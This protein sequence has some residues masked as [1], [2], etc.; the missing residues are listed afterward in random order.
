MQ[1]SFAYAVD[2]RIY[3]LENRAQ[4]YDLKIALRIAKLV[5]KLRFEVNGT[6]FDDIDPIS[7]LA[8]LK[9]FCDACHSIGIHK[10]VAMWLMSYI[11][12]KPALSALESRFSSKKNLCDWSAR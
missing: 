11:M 5:E 1:K 3:R 6:N 10:G 4:R 8:F 9:K 2:Y 7:N 12:T